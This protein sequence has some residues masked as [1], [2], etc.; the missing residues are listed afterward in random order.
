MNN[1]MLQALLES[2]F[3]RWLMGH[4]NL[5]SCT[6]SS[7]RDS[8]RLL[9][10]WLRSHRGIRPDEVTFDDIGRETIVAFLDDLRDERGC[11]PKT[12]NCRLGAIKSFA[13]YVASECPERTCWVK[14]I[15]S[16]KQRRE[17]KPVLDYL[18]PNEV[19]M[20]VESCDE[21]SLEGRRDAMTIMLLFN[22]G[23]RVTELI[24]L[25]A[26]SFDFPGSGSCRATVIGKGRK[27]RTVPLWPE[28]AG[29]IESY[30][31]EASISG[32][33]YLLPGRN[34]DHLTRSGARTRLDA[35]CSR[36][37]SSNPQLKRK[38]ITPH[39]LRHSTAMAMLAAGIDLST[40]AIWLG[41][42]SIQTTHMYMIADMEMKE[43]ALEQAS[44]K[45]PFGEP[46]HS[47]LY[48][49]DE[50]ILAFLESL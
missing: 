48:E 50:S 42:E 45:N 15:S 38:R 26:S 30:M 8:F 27:E 43:R 17:A 24:E 47:V 39:V 28:T 49:P 12:I 14:E 40:I 4:R 7:Y 11:S 41:H 10:C 9:L 34:V 36:A 22:S 29:S 35:I 44:C 16:I 5:S 18:T 20:L 6:V 37:I 2:W 3:L 21:T 25:K 33:S 31:R 46:R 1:G 19:R 23:F 13:D 32:D